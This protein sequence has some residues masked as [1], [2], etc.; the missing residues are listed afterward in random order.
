M[1][2]QEAILIQKVSF[3][4]ILKLAQESYRRRIT[5][6]SCGRGT[7]SIS[8]P[9]AFGAKDDLKGISLTIRR[10]SLVWKSIYTMERK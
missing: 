3:L 1:N 5:L 7:F 6:V 8:S 9:I 10:L 4:A 2:L